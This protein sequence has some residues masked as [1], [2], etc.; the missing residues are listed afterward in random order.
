MAQT[1]LEELM[2]FPPVDRVIY[3]HAPL[4]DVTCELRFAPILKI[5]ADPPAWFQDQIR[6]DYP[7]YERT[8][9]SLFSNAP[10]EVRSLIDSVGASSEDKTVHKFFD[11]AQDWTVSLSRDSISI[12]TTDYERWEEFRDRASKVFSAVVEAYNPGQF[13]RVGLR[14]RD[15]IIRSHV[16]LAG[17]P[18]AELLQPQIAGELGDPA[19]DEAS[20]DIAIRQLRFKFSESN[21]DTITVNVSH[22]LVVDERAADEELSYLVDADFYSEEYSDDAEHAFKILEN[23]HRLAAGLW[24]WSITDAL[25]E[26]LG[27]QPA[28]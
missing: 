24:R 17:I 22:G 8:H 28:A 20:V 3:D 10:A 26:A 4:F 11:D 16:G 21:S 19:I 15:I 23:A 25:H 18:W 1:V 13:R 9:T 7:G 27:P 14:Y 2:A 6:A 12:A 5:D